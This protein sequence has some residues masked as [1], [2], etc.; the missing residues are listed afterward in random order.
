MKRRLCRK[1]ATF[2][3]KY[4]ARETFRE[5]WQILDDTLFPEN[6]F[7][8]ALFTCVMHPN[9]FYVNVKVKGSNK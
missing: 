8:T 5:K 7:V 4:P 2:P 3:E 1:A 9:Y 6:K